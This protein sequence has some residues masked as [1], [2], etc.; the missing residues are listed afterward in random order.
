MIV[1]LPPP[2]KPVLST[3]EVICKL[4]DYRRLAIKSQKSRRIRI[5]NMAAG[6]VM[7]YDVAIKLLERRI[8]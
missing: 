6:R 3:K 7:A 8:R 2:P 1:R 4:R 5:S